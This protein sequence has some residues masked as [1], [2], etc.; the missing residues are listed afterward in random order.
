MVFHAVAVA[1]RR[2]FSGWG[3]IDMGPVKEKERV[4]ASV[5]CA[6]PS[7]N[8][9]HDFNRFNC[10]T[11][12]P[13]RLRQQKKKACISRESNTGLAEVERLSTFGNG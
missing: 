4:D 11:P 8:V 2:G 9:R 3:S 12:T 6:E 13:R 10:T 5:T 7:R 1:M